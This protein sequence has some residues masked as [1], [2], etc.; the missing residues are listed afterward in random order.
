MIEQL[1]GDK[2][3]IVRYGGAFAV[4]LAY[5]G[6]GLTKATRKLL[7]IAVTDVNDDVRRAALTGI[8]FVLFK[9]PHQCPSLMQLLVDS[10]NPH[11]RYGAAMALGIACAG[12]A[13]STAIDLL[14]PLTRDPV[15]FV[16]QGALIAMGLIL[17]ETN[18]TE[19]PRLEDFT[20]TCLEIIQNK[21]ESVLS[22]IGAILALGLVN[23]GGRN[24]TISCATLN[25]STNMRAVVGLAMFS[26]YWFWQPYILFACLSMT[27]TAV[28]ALNSELTQVPLRFVSN[29]A[30]SQFAYP[31]GMKPPEKATV[32][33][34]PTA[35]LSYGHG[36]AKP[37]ATPSSDQKDQK[38]QKVDKEEAS[39]KVVTK[40]KE[41]SS[42]TLSSPCRVT[43][44][45]RKY[46]SFDV[47]AKYT[48]VKTGIIHGITLVHDNDVPQPMATDEHDSKPTTSNTTTSTTT[49]TTTQQKNEAKND[50]DD[51][52][53]P[54][55]FELPS[56]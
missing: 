26:Q 38:D 17:V 27:P 32:A 39:K 3:P 41:P 7:H 48:P 29:V 31:E 53:A 20:K 8:G 23:A 10:F 47:D 34:G 40:P 28:I 14:E 12:T 49:T 6:S 56:Q 19:V 36:K 22:S 18:K 21:N 11:T 25:G 9:H 43:M 16:R 42:E 4:A 15:D 54:P 51:P 46:L 5:C 2:D 45:Q 30:P 35:V 24:V 13:L 52:V 50:D 55:P 44:R 33:K 1:V 37:K